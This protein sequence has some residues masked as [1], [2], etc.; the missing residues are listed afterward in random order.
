MNP[1][2]G[3]ELVVEAD[4]SGR[5]ARVGTIVAV[6]ENNG[7][8]AYLVHWVVGDYDALVSPWPGVHVKHREHHT[9]TATPTARQRPAWSASRQVRGQSPKRPLSAGSRA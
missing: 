3:D 1:E 4:A 7:R 2:P 9:T 6:R 5:S 8:P